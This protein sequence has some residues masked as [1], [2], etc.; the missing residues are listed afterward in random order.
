MG[1]DGRADEI[2]HTANVVWPVLHGGATAHD[3]DAVQGRQGHREQ[4][5]AG[6]AVGRQC[7]RDAIGQGLDSPTA[8][9]VQAA[10]GNLRQGAG[11]GFVEDLYPRHTLQGIV[12]APY[13]GR[14]QLGGVNHAAA[15]GV[16][17]HLLVA[18]AAQDIA[19]DHHGGD[20]GRFGRR[21]HGRCRL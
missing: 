17:A 3:V 8:A 9:F 18:G 13:A 14:F 7:Q 2:D 21:R 10:H 19:L 6:L 5:Q 20:E 16:G 12:H 11:A 15:A 4:R 1:R